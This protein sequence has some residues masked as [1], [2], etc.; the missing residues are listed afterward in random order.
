MGILF[1]P[2]LW[3]FFRDDDSRCSVRQLVAHNAVGFLFVFV[4]VWQTHFALASTVNPALP[5][6]GYYQASDEYKR[7]LSAGENGSIR[8]FGV[9]LRDSM[10]FVGH[11]QSGIPSLISARAVRMAACGSCGRSVPGRSTTGGKRRAATNRPST[12]TSTSSP[13][14]RGGFSDFSASFWPPGCCSYPYWCHCARGS[15]TASCWWCSWASGWPT[16]PPSV[17]SIG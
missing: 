5:G 1:I 17:D 14:Q 4:A 7:I 3:Q 8:H 13:T 9:M 10:D 12:G 6:Q 2:L 16:W 15:R 11:Y